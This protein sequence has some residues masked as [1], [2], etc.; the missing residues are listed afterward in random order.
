MRYLIL[1]I[2]AIA[3]LLTCASCCLKS[4]RLVEQRELAAVEAALDAKIAEKKKMEIER[5]YDAIIIENAFI[6]YNKVND[7]V[8]VR[9]EDNVFFQKRPSNMA[10][11]SKFRYYRLY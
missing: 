6:T 2:L 1:F 9:V 10:N 4:E 8:V 11:S 7:S 3:L 5:G